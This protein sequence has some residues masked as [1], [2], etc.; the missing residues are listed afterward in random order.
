[1][2]LGTRHREAGLLLTERGVPVLRTPDG[3]TWR[4]VIDRDARR[5]LGHRV[6]LDGVRVGFDLL[7]VDACWPAGEP[8][9]ARRA[10][11]HLAR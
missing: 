6:E 5:L 4:L 1:M 9:P 11:W 3:G 2:P 7:D 10:W 8:R